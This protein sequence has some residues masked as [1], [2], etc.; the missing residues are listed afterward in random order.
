MKTPKTELVSK[1]KLVKKPGAKVHAPLSAILVK[2][3]DELSAKALWHTSGLAID[4]FYRQL[5]TEMVNGW[6]AEP[7]KAHV[8]I[9]DGQGNAQ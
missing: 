7:Q 9:T 8:R 2:N 4:D 5:K 1:L 6:I 3:N